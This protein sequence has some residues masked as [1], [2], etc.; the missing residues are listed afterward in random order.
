M[1]SRDTWL[2]GKERKDGSL[3]NVAHSAAL[4]PRLLGLW[5][6]G[7]IRSITRGHR[8]TV[9]HQ[10]YHSF[11]PGKRGHNSRLTSRTYSLLGEQRQCTL[12]DKCQ[13]LSHPSRESNPGP[14][15]CELNALP[16]RH[17]TVRL[18]LKHA[19]KFPL[20]FHDHDVFSDDFSRPWEKHLIPWLPVIIW[21]MIIKH[22]LNQYFENITVNPCYI[23]QIGGKGLSKYPKVR[24]TRWSEPPLYTE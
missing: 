7:G 16:L 22:S 6:C 13:F 23:E 17:G 11:L 24:C 3:R 14:L 21:S 12:R 18:F 4:I 8:A 5:A 19:F 20:L 15:G 1:R 2:V 9:T 10:G